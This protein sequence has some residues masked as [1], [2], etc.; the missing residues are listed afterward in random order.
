MAIITSPK[1]GKMKN[2]VDGL[3]FQ[4][5]RTLQVMR[6]RVI[7]RNPRTASQQLA[8]AKFGVLGAMAAPFSPILGVGLAEYVKGTVMGVRNAFIKLNKACVTGSN[9][10]SLTVDYTNMVI[11][12]GSLTNVTFGGLAVDNPLE[13][14][15]DFT[16]NTEAWDADAD[17]I[18]RVFIYCPDLNSVISVAPVKRSDGNVTSTVPATW[19]GQRVNVWGFTEGNVEKNMGKISNSAYIGSDIIA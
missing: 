6:D 12:K 17:D 19:A 5:Y 13:V 14:A 3:V 16:P 2:K 4:K 1:F 7:P 8:R 10:N 9:P 15:V 11:A 18:V